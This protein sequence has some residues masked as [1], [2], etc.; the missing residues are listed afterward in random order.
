MIDAAGLLI[1]LLVALIA[2]ALV[3]MLIWWWGRGED[4]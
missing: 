2:A 4:A 3:G 1:G